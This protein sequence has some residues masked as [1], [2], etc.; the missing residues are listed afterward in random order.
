MTPEILAALWQLKSLASEEVPGTAEALLTR[1][2]DTPAV[3]ELAGLVRPV[4]S[5]AEPIVERALRELGVKRPTDAEA[6]RSLAAFWAAEILAGRLDPYVGARRIWTESWFACGQP[7]D[8]IPF[9]GLAS[10]YEDSPEHRSELV[11]DIV[12]AAKEYLDQHPSAVA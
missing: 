12:A 8:L 1:G 2:Y 7:D 5:D 3:V 10:Q 4:R 11:A 6:G 9:V